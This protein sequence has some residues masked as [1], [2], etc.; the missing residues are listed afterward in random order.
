MGRRGYN[1]GSTVIRPGSDWFGQG[2]SGRRRRAFAAESSD[3]PATARDLQVGLAIKR[4]LIK[5]RATAKPKPL[6]APAEPPVVASH[7]AKRAGEKKKRNKSK[8]CRRKTPSLPGPAAR[9]RSWV[10]E[11]INSPL[12]HSSHALVPPPQAVADNVDAPMATSG[13]EASTRP[14]RV[15]K[16]PHER[17]YGPKTK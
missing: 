12:L 11:T 14:K 9:V 6:P 7:I 13:G 1:G 8:P 10:A 16:L 2:N 5:G 3:L 15:H 17:W 4:G